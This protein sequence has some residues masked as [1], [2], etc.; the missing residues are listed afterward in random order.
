MP[1]EAPVTTATRCGLFISGS[2]CA[3]VV[4]Q[5]TRAGLLRWHVGVIGLLPV[6]RPN[7]PLAY[8]CGVELRQLRYFLAVAEELNFGR[9]AERLRIAG[10]SLSQQIK[11][12]E[13]DLKV[14]LFD[15]DR[16][17]VALTAAD[18]ALLPGARS[19]V[20]QADDLRRS[21]M[22]MAMTEP[23]RVGY[24]NWCPGDLA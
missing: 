1:C 14:S 17:S 19:L 3:G 16:R 13:R 5:S 20:Q 11:A 7:L 18:T 10:P 24:V 21:A 15:R 23:V 9:A 12:L 8:A 22:G 6:G 2:L 4:S